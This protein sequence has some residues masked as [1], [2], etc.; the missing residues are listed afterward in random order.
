M[1]RADLKR[2]SSAARLLRIVSAVQHN[3]LGEAELG[4]GPVRDVRRLVGPAAFLVV[5]DSRC[6]CVLS[7]PSCADL[8]F[9][10]VAAQPAT[11]VRMDAV[12]AY[13]LKEWFIFPPFAK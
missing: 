2:P 6:D 3:R 7:S 12:I 10:S 9:S 5:V 13:V 1:R 8:K 4:A 11:T